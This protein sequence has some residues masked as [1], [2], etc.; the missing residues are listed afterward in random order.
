VNDQRLAELFQR[1]IEHPLKVLA[2]GLLFIAATGAGLG[3]L[4]KDTSVDAFVPENHSAL[5]ANAQTTELFGLT[6]PIAV[7]LFA[8]EGRLVFEREIMAALET[9]TEALSDLD[10]INADRVASIASESSISGASGSIEVESYLSQGLSGTDTAVSSWRNMPP[11]IATLV[12]EDGRGAVILAELTDPKLSAE[13][14]VAVRELMHTIA[15]S[16]L[17]VQ[18]AGPAAVSGYLSQYIDADARVLQ[19]FVFLVVL[20]F[21]YLAFM[22]S[23][24]LLG[25]VIVIVGSTVGALGTMAWMGIPYYAITN[26]LPL[27]LVAISA[28]DAIHVLSAYFEHKAEH[29]DRTQ[30]QH[31]VAAMVKMARPITLTTVTTVAGFLGIAAVSI[32]PPIYYFALFAMLGVVIAWCFSLLI[33]P[34]ALVLLQPSQSRFFVNWSS[35][36]PDTVGKQ[37]AALSTVG[38]LKPRWVLVCFTAVVA[39]AAIGAASLKIDRSQVDN[40]APTEPLRIADERI[41]AEFAGTAFLDVIVRGEQDGALLLREN[42]Q[43]VAELQS[44]LERQDHVSKTVSIVD[45]ISLLDD[46]ISETTPGASRKIPL[47]DDAIA[48]YLMVYEA[49]GDPTDFDEEITRDYR[50][51]LVRGVLDSHYFSDSRAVVTALQEHI[52]QNFSGS[53]LTATIAGDI[54]VSYHWMTALQSTHFR[55]VGVSIA[56]ILLVSALVFRSFTTG[57]V[58]V[59]PVSFTILC[60]Y[61]VMGYLGIYLE[62]ATSMF[63]AIS[64]GVGVDFAI[65]FIDRVL[66]HSRTNDTSLTLAVNEVA[67][68][69]GRACFFNAAAL[70][71]GFSV[72]MISDLPT[73]QRFGG[74]VTVAAV[75]SFLCALVIIP[76]LFTLIDRSSRAPRPAAIVTTSLVVLLCG[77]ILLPRPIT[78]EGLSGLELANQVALREEAS[79]TK[80]IIAMTLRDKRGKTREREAMVMRSL[81]SDIRSTRVTYLHPKPVRELTFLSKDFLGQARKDERWLYIPAVG[82]VRRIPASDRGDYFLGTDFTFEDMQ[83]DLKFDVSDYEFEYGGRVNHGGVSAHRLTG[84]PVSRAVAKQLGYG[85]FSAIV[86]PE[87]WFPLQIEFFDLKLEPLKTVIV[88]GLQRVDGIWTPARIEAQHHRTGHST[89]FVYTDIEHAIELPSSLFRAQ[90]LVRGLPGK[91]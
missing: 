22:K 78:A 45:Y 36:T 19:P 81:D 73:L 74:L 52:D 23:S 15:P 34:P 26:A 10:N 24:A 21:L 39:L 33:L 54:N 80:R 70:S 44:F 87:S 79:T 84:R 57:I 35:A 86:D 66:Q 27:I 13:T 9:I 72:L 64:V 11:H 71:L 47:G 8:P 61:G 29:P 58:A 7:A 4:E 3:K 60:L 40:F 91:W 17:E 55:G 38:L 37:L 2:L 65:H 51:A 6:E 62:P 46:A 30:Q 32:M 50:A 85:S 43:K 75:S 14:Y 25:P 63:A 59:I 77:A 76:A 82:K 90:E 68:S 31:V 5:V 67:P 41:H 89:L 83:S 20:T 48:Q 53:E 69:T 16:F 1:L 49:S 18:I 42:M 12:S 56:L 88:G 28:A